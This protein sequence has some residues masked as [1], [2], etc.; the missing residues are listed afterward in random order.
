MKLTTKNCFPL[1]ASDYY[2]AYLTF[3]CNNKPHN[4]PYNQTNKK[5]LNQSD[6]TPHI[7]NPQRHKRNSNSAK[8]DHYNSEVLKE[9]TI[10]PI[11]RNSSIS[12]YAANTNQGIVRFTHDKV[13]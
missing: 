8:L 12:A 9:K 3:D 11:P 6:Y 13:I 10:Q 5:P 2:S 4:C 7:H 1:S